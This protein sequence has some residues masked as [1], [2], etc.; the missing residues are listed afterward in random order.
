VKIW[1]DVNV[2]FFNLLAWAVV[3]LMIYFWMLWNSEGKRWNFLKST[4]PWM[5]GFVI[6]CV[7]LAHMNQ[8]WIRVE[9]DLVYSEN[10]YG[11]RDEK[12][13]FVENINRVYI[14][15]GKVTG[16]NSYTYYRLIVADRYDDWFSVG[17]SAG[18][19]FLVPARD[20]LT[21][22]LE[23]RGVKVSNDPPPKTP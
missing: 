7:A 23:S 8:L 1:T 17:R 15:S 11:F 9:N 22:F 13:L 2:D 14:L 4:I 6:F 10:T 5:F 21:R 19:S 16:K 18:P 3:P 20:Q 12:S